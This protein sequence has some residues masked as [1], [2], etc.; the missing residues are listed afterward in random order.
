MNK[1]QM[2]FDTRGEDSTIYTYDDA[3]K[4]QWSSLEAQLR[5][6]ALNSLLNEQPSLPTLHPINLSHV[7]STEPPVPHVPNLLSH[8]VQLKER[9]MSNAMMMNFSRLDNST[10]SADLS[11]RHD[12]EWN[13]L[14]ASEPK[15]V[16]KAIPSKVSIGPMA[17]SQRSSRR[18]S[19]RLKPEPRN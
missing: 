10:I 16:S 17:K 7:S 9:M 8:E 4:N 3:A 6:R 2:T 14:N 5:N 19:V 18:S 11:G 15:I 13:P 12:R 1:N